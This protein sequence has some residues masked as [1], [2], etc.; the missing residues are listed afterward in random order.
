MRVLGVLTIVLVNCKPAL[1][2]KQNRDQ[3]SLPCCAGGPKGH[4]V[5]VKVSNPLLCSF[6]LF[7][8]NYAAAVALT[9]RKCAS[10]II[11]KGKQKWPEMVMQV[12]VT[13]MWYAALYSTLISL[14]CKQRLLALNQRSGLHLYFAT[15]Q[16]LCLRLFKLHICVHESCT[17]RPPCSCSMPCKKWFS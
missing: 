13:C 6:V 11:R 4:S 16:E 5:K 8:I 15:S 2:R 3:F 14:L 1:R 10:F 7:Y 12:I 17:L 9:L